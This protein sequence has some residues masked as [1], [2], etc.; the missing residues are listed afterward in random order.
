M[1]KHL[2]FLVWSPEGLPFFTIVPFWVKPCRGSP[3]PN[4][5]AWRRGLGRDS[6][7]VA[8]GLHPASWATVIAVDNRQNHKGWSHGGGRRREEKSFSIRPVGL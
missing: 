6:H 1:L 8:G 4:I 5:T 3:L 7:I 2:V